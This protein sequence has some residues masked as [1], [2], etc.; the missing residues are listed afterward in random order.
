MSWWLWH[1][2][3]RTPV[4]PPPLPPLRAVAVVV[5]VAGAQVY[6]DDAVPPGPHRGFTNATGYVEFAVTQLPVSRLVVEADGFLPYEVNGLALPLG[7]FQIRVGVE[8]DPN[9][10][11]D[12]ILGPLVP[13]KPPVTRRT[14]I[15]SLDGRAFADAGGPWLAVGA[16]FFWGLWGWQYDRARTERNLDYLAERG[17]GR[18]DYLRVFAVVG[19]TSWDDRTAEPTALGYDEAFTGFLDGAVARGM[20]TEVTI[21]ASGRRPDADDIVRQLAA[22]ASPRPE[23]IQHWEIA[24]EGMGTGWG[25]AAGIAEM[26]ELARLL[27]SLVPQPVALTAAQPNA[28]DPERAHRVYDG[29]A[30]NL[31]TEH[32][33]RDITGTGGIWRPVRQAWDPPFYWPGAWSSN[34]PIGPQSSVNEDDDPLRLTMAAAYT[35]LCNGCGYV[36]HAGAGIRG[37]G[38]GDQVRGRVANFW[39][40]AHIDETLAGIAAVRSLLPADFPNFERH[41]SNRNFPGYPFESD[42]IGQMIANGRL[43]RAFAATAGDRL[44]C[45]PILA[46]DPVPFTARRSM[47]LDVYNPLTGTRLEAHDLA[48]SQTYMMSPRDAAVLV[49][50]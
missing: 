6:L 37:G 40:V 36:L 50:R 28:A 43:L 5:P 14:G 19:G 42:P 22:L 25:D 1:R 16:S 20:K 8:R 10:P 13:E 12:V 32:L 4:G 11:Q 44:V 2:H 7:D 48:A 47:H 24:N 15:V 31:L 23:T 49:G 41:N 26:R 33:D 39:E 9:R 45:M 3:P 34:E 21:F 30:A 46:L 17:A 35:W 29:S 18:P 38:S 27:R